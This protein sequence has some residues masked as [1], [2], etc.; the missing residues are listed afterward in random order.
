MSCTAHIHLHDDA[1]IEGDISR[2][3]CGTYVSIDFRAPNTLASHVFTSDPE[4]LDLIASMATRLAEQL[5]AAQEE[6]RETVVLAYWSEAHDGP[7][8]Y[9]WNPEDQ[10]D[11]CDAGSVGAFA[12]REE[13]VKHL[14]DAGYRVEP[15]V[16]EH[17]HV[18]DE[19]PIGFGGSRSE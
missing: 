13:A 7:G 8:W 15:E 1:I 2:T 6:E 4:H 12:T 10:H 14:H 5:R 17:D 11:P 19:H 18:N 16:T 9:Y 3:D